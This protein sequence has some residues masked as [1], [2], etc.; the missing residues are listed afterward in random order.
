MNFLGKILLG[1][2]AVTLRRGSG[3]LLGAVWRAVMTPDRKYGRP[4]AQRPPPPHKAN[5]PAVTTGTGNHHQQQKTASLKEA[6]CYSPLSQQRCDTT[7][8]EQVRYD[9][10]GVAKPFRGA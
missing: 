1:L 8:F 10:N 9:Q 7:Q 5:H 6:D 4:A 2:A 3:K